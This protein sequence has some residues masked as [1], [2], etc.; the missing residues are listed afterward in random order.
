MRDV[1]YNP[2]KPYTVVSAGDDNRIK[3][4]DV[5]KTESPL[6]SLAGHSHWVWRTRYNPFHDQLLLSSSTDSTVQLW[7]VSSISSAP[8]LEMDDEEDNDGG[9]DERQAPDEVVKTFEDHEDSVYG[10]AWSACDA[11]AFAS[12]SYDGRVTIN[13]VPSAEKYKI[14]L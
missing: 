13:T 4:W 12:L 1:H 7:R 5:R 6:L 8:V 14:L 3:F 10:L 9:V 11:W 2:N